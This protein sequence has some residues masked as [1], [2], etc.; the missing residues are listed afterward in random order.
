MNDS[1]VLY[2]QLIDEDSSKPWFVILHGLFGSSPNFT[3]LAK[4]LAPH[5]R[6]IRM[7]LPN[8]GRSYHTPEHNYPLMAKA[9]LDSLDQLGVEQ[10]S[11]LGH[12]MGGKV[13]MQIAAQAT[14][15]LE[16]LIVVDISPVAYPLNSHSDVLKALNG[17]DFT[18]ASSRQDIDAQMAPFV[19]DPN[20]RQFLMTNLSR[21]AGG[22]EWRVNLPV[23]TR[24][25][26]NIAA[27][28]DLPASY[29][30]SCLFIRGGASDY[31][32]DEHSALIKNHF[33][34][35]QLDTIDGAGHWLH[36][37][38]PLEFW[39]SLSKFLSI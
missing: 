33:P 2:H 29:E 21:V 7:D 34:N 3:S 1:A 6:V 22:F 10:F 26:A 39:Q 25:Y 12:S 32:T 38:K 15:R 16:N 4:A 17:V 30:K 13:A 18:V 5:Y 35:M 20:L 28:P 36:A 11:L 37:E 23:L 19:T 27:A 14:S 8:H 31:I 9:V 24:D